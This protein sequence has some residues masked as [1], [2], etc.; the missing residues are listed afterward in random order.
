MTNEPTTSVEPSVDGRPAGYTSLTPFLCIDGAAAA[1]D[2]YVEAFAASVVTR[3]DGPDGTVA[4]AELD[5]GSGRLQLADPSPAYHL[6]APDGT[7]DV[8]HST[9]FYCADVDTTFERA[10]ALGAKVFEPPSTFVTG[11]RF[12]AVLDP[13]GHRWAIITRVEDIDPAEAERRVEAWLAEQ[14]QEG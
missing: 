5:F 6:V 7:D 14:Q 12:A 9:V 1:I 10:V 4:H 3:N 8:N 11:D 2:F 13:F